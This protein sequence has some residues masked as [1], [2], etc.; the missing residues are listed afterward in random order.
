MIE[1]KLL[2]TDKNARVGEIKTPSGVIKTPVFMPVGTL[3]VVK[4][5]DNQD[6]YNLDAQIIL[7]NTYHLFL[8]PGVEILKEFNGIRNMMNI[9]IPMLTD[10][11][12]FQVFSLKEGQKITEDGV[13]F[14]SHLSGERLFISPEISIDIQQAIGADIMMV[15][16]EC[17]PYNVSY[18]YLKASAERT[19]RWA[20]RCLDHRT[21]DQALF[22]IVQGGKYEDLRK[23]SADYLTSLPFDGYAI[24][25]V[26]I[27][28][29]KEVMLEMIEYGIKYLPIDKP[30]YLMGVGSIDGLLEGIERGVDMFDC[31]IPT[32]L[33]RHGAVLTRYGRLNLRDKQ[34]ELDKTAI[35]SSCTCDTCR[36]YSKAYLHHLI[37]CEEL[38]YKRLLTIHNINFLLNLMKKAREAILENRFV[39]F[40]K[41]VYKDYGEETIRNKGF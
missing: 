9:N 26:A 11:G 2:H 13:Y 1:F 17:P 6:L 24:G 21:T 14:K 10:S 20:K 37:K 3:G 30:R 4:S 40:K 16:D 25:G 41:Q 19:S 22:G 23:A 7:S 32:R 36:T 38:T 18:E 33:A 29:E 15:F 35:D 28:E 27:G 8:R 31:V 34:Y 39:E 12:G 5:L